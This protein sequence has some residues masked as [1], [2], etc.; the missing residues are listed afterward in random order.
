MGRRC[1]CC[2]HRHLRCMAWPAWPRACVARS[3]NRGA[4]NGS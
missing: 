3:L 2:H 4:S 1:W